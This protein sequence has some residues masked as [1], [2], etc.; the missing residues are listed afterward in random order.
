M[1]D[2]SIYV[3]QSRYTTSIVEKLLYTAT[4]NKSA[5]F[6]KTTFPSDIIFTK[7]DAFTSDEQVAKLTMEY[8]IVYIGILLKVLEI[9][10]WIL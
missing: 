4:V 10:L 1:N 5:I 7:A 3:Y 2:H 8:N 9:G 6:Y